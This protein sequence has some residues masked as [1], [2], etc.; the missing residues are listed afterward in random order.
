[1]SILDCQTANG[2]QSNSSH[3]SHMIM[4]E[5]ANEVESKQLILVRSEGFF[6]EIARRFGCCRAANRYCWTR[7]HLGLGS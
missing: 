6:G 5:N 7:K 1:M 2:S 3:E 4:Q